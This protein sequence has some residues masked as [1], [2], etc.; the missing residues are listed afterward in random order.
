MKFGR[1]ELIRVMVVAPRLVCWGLEELVKS[2]SSRF[3]LVGAVNSF[4]EAR[5]AAPAFRPDAVVIDLD[6]PDEQTDLLAFVEACHAPV[7]AL[8][9]I[10]D[11]DQI[12]EAMLNGLSGIVHKR[13]PPMILHQAIETVARGK[14]RGVR[15]VVA[16]SRVKDREEPDSA[17]AKLET[18]TPRQRKVFR[19][20]MSDGA[21]SAQAMASRL[22][23]STYTLREHLS[24]IYSKFR[25]RNRLALYAYAL[26]HKLDRRDSMDTSW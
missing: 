19:L 3:E 6:W 15:S 24:V 2:A 5:S 23:I 13:E 20:L 22:S 16:T 4:A 25:V 11:P 7:V 18:L 21:A 9:G 8:T 26:R 1:A 17:F 12:D 14:S 10:N